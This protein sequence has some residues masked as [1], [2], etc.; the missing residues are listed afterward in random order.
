MAKVRKKIT[1]AMKIAFA[2]EAQAKAL[3]Y[4]EEFA[5]RREKEIQKA[6]SLLIRMG[7]ISDWLA[8]YRA[9]P[10]DKRD[11][12]MDEEADRV[13]NSLSVLDDKFEAIPDDIKDEAR[14]RLTPNPKPVRFGSAANDPD[15]ILPR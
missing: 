7:N 1:R 5:L 8:N 9:M 4:N 15:V 14:Q 2:Q 6:I 11:Y 3:R 13:A 12:D 10:E